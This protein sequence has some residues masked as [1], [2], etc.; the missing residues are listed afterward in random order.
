MAEAVI[1]RQARR[2]VEGLYF[3][4]APRWHAGRLYFSD[5]Y[6][7]AVR[8]LN[9]DGSVETIVEVPNQ[10]SG[11]GWLPDGRMLVVSMLDRRLLSF[12]GE[13]LTEYADLSSV[14][15]YHSNDLLVDPA[16]RAFVGNFGYDLHAD[17]RARGVEGV[18]A[19]SPTTKLA[20]V[21]P[22]GTVTVAAEDLKFPNGMV[23]TPSGEFVVAETTA[24]CLTAFTMHADGT[25]SNRR[26][27]AS[28]ANAELLLAPDG[29]CVDAEGAIWA[30]NPLGLDVVRFKEGGEILGRVRTSQPSFA[31]MLGGEDRKTLYVMTAPTSDPELAASSRGGV[32][33]ACE[34]DVPGAGLP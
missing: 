10:P 29:I 26:V 34:V 9:A 33:E 16:G 11:L 1:T 2:L 7:R 17:L 15:T 21:D 28:T 25:L 6:E 12:D 23:L 30:T 22:D 4:E 19:S 20:R 32:I 14:A 27:W 5:F 24:P 8:A 13:R 18:L 31:C 3:G